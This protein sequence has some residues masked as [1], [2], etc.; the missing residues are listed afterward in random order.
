MASTI[1][2]PTY[3]PVTTATGLA[4]S[5]V[6]PRQ[7]ALDA[8]SKLASSA[9]SAL[10]TLNSAISTFRTALSTLTGINKSLY[11]QS[12]TFSDTKY[13][14]GTASAAAAP[15]NYAIF[16]KKLATASQ[17]RFQGLTQDEGVGGSLK[18]KMGGADAFSVN[19]SAADTDGDGKLSTRE[20]ALAIN[21]APDNAGKVTASIIN[22]GTSQELVLTSKETGKNT[23]ITLDTSGL[24]GPSSLKDANDDASRNSTLVEADD[25]EIYL[26][27][28]DGAK[29]TQASNTFTAI[30]GL[31]MTFTKAQATGEDP[32]F[33]SV[34]AD[35]SSTK[36]NVQSFVDAFNALKSSLSKLTSTGNSEKGVAAG[37]FANDGGVRALADRLTSLLNSTSG[38]T[39]VRYGISTT[40]TGTL[41]LDSDKLMAQLERDPNGLDELLGRAT[42]ANPTG[43]AGALDK[44]LDSWNNTVN[45]QIKQRRDSIER[46]QKQLTDRQTQIDKAY[47][48]AYARYLKQFTAL[49]S[50]QSLVGSNLTMLDAL[51]SND[52]D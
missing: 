37:A 24:T 5:Y 18:V 30:E 17:V 22:T 11:A 29:I 6:I 33:V 21:K 26:G 41:S 14:S 49:Q 23:K 20:L 15:G 38:D 36:T 35:N 42:K 31:K 16:V 44:Y 34:G 2:A 50:M 13:G 45:G 46:Q 1:N 27:G 25:A 12:A 28:I 43:I 7:Q 10:N 9:S 8:K 19:L 39:L 3:D 48:S 40:R 52:K 51:F 47:E 32:F 4:E